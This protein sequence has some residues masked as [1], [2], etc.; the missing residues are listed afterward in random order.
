M[1]AATEWSPAGWF[2]LAEEVLPHFHYIYY[3]F[4]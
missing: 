1:T 2:P 4:F 3:V